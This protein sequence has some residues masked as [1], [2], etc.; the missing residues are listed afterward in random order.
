MRGDMRGNIGFGSGLGGLLGGLFGGGD[1]QNPY[2]RASQVAG[3][4]W[5]EIHGFKQQL[6]PY[7][8]Q[9]EQGMS[10]LMSDPSAMIDHIMG[11]YHESPFAQEQTAHAQKAA[12]A[13]AALGGTVGTPQ[14]QEAVAQR[15]GQISDADQNQYLQN[16]LGQYRFGAQGMG[17]LERQIPGL[18]GQ[19]GNYF[20]NMA[21]LA[22]Q[23]ADW[24]NK[25]NQGFG[26]GIGSLLGG[27][28]GAILG[29][30]GHFL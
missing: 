17:G 9:Y 20:G 1:N 29:A 11:H 13:A 8:Q 30:K 24:Q 4:F 25:Q 10:G 2:D 3:Q 6:M 28:I 16:V 7:A 27:G 23:S 22:G 26:G 15:V 12:N 14:E 5:P 21:Q 19:E 18:L